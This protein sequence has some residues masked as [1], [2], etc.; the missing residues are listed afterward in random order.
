MNN[1]RFASLAM[2][3]ALLMS[4]CGGSSSG[5]PDKSSPPPTVVP[6]PP[7]PPP[8]TVDCE[9][10]DVYTL[11]VTIQ[12]FRVSTGTVEHM[13][14][15]F[16]DVYPKLAERFNRGAPLHVD[17]VIGPASFIAGASGNSV[18]YQAS[19]LVLNPED[20]D[21]VVHEVT[22]IVQAYT[23]APGW[24]TEGIADYA[25]YRYGVNNVRAG[26][27][28]RPPEPGQ[29]YTTGYGTTARFLVWVEER[30]AVE[31]ANELNAALRAGEYQPGLWV[32][33]TGKSVDA[34]WADYVADPS[35]AEGPGAV[36]N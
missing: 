30:Y 25:R 14:E 29:S 33:L 21:V 5:S 27:N 6:P 34:L 2:V 22:H 28:I 4:A 20:Y 1:R 24:L 18:T 7:P 36:P 3:S 35:L 11:C 10:R 9:T 26:W 16:F 19:W 31:L 32:T 12:D 8:P 17:F 15:S 13:T 23:T